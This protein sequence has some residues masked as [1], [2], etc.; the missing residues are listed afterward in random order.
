MG[1]EEYGFHGCFHTVRE[2]RIVW[3]FTF[4]GMPDA[5]CLETFT[6]EELGDGRTLLRSDSLYE[7]F[8]ARDFML[9]SMESGVIDAYAQLDRLLAAARAVERADTGRG[10]V[11]T[12]GHRLSS[13]SRWTS[14]N[15]P[16]SSPSSWP[17]SP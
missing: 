13:S 1:T 15:A 9:T 16:S 14:P 2:D 12:D 3:T 17:W 8:E 7:S 6:F 5:V 10:C 11:A 4:E